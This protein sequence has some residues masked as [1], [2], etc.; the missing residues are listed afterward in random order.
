VRAVLA[1]VQWSVVAVVVLLVG[2]A[3]QPA[4]AQP[5]IAQALVGVAKKG[6]KHHRSSRCSKAKKSG[7]SA[8]KA[9]RKHRAK[10]KKC[11]KPKRTTTHPTQTGP[12]TPVPVPTPAPTAAPAPTPAPQGNSTPASPPP[13][14]TPDYAAILSGKTHWWALV[15]S[16]GGCGILGQFDHS[17]PGPW[18]LARA[19][20]YTG[21]GPNCTSPVPLSTQVG[22]WRV[23]GD[24]ISL[25]QGGTT[26]TAKILSYDPNT[27]EMLSSGAPG[28]LGHLYGCHS[29]FNPFACPA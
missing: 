29:P 9:K 10:K 2:L 12:V 5:T 27:D 17:G 6:H 25:S 24:T 28:L 1:K 19:T 14:S 20:S 4:E 21:L 7:A 3:A 13:P 16:G 23:D 8:A 26:T 18:Y 15:S 22:L 11:P